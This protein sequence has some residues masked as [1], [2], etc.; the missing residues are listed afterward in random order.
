MSINMKFIAL[1]SAGVVALAGAGLYAGTLTTTN[2]G[3]VGA[4]NVALQASC[5]STAAVNPQAATWDATSKKFRYTKVNVSGTLTNCTNQ[6]A[7][8]NIYA[9]ADG[10]VLSTNATP[11]T[12]SSDEVTAGTFEVIL[13]TPV[14]AA[15]VDTLYKYGLVIQTA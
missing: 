7:T 12:I 1:G 5:T 15:V 3:Q 11:K 13:D 9:I 8:V 4:G 14:D 10:Q 6:K 2:T